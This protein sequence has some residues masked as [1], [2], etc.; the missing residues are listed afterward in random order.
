[1]LEDAYPELGD[2]GYDVDSD[3]EDYS[4]MDRVGKPQAKPWDFQTEEE[5]SQYKLGRE[6]N[7][8]AAYQFGVKMKDGRRDK[9]GLKQKGQAS[10]DAK[11]N[12]QW[13]QIQQIMAKRDGGRTPAHHSSGGGDDDDRV[14]K[15][16]RILGKR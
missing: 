10:E 7:P 8:K 15:R 6:A 11:L 16:A 4:Q 9:S 1:M 2:I 14:S 5:Y 13:Q 12:K 3:D